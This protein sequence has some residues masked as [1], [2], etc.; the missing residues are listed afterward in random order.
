MF[1]IKV[2]RCR[3]LSSRSQ[4][5]PLPLVLPLLR[6][7]LDEPVSV[8]EVLDERRVTGSPDDESKSNASANAAT[9]IMFLIT[10]SSF[11]GSYCE[12]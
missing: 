5:S 3:E 1:A 9:N 6:E 8:D 4:L 12:R 10:A 2:S 11:S 7:R